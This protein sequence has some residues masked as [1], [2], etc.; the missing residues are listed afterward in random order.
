LR[1]HEIAARLEARLLST[2]LEV[3]AP[4]AAELIQDALR[5]LSPVLRA[6]DGVITTVTG[7]AE[8]A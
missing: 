6:L 7:R 1:V 5:R 8:V 4:A 3:F 2:P